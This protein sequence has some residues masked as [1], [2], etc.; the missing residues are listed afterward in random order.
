[1]TNDKK[2]EDIEFRI[3]TMDDLE[4]AV[5]FSIDV[6]RLQEPL[7]NTMG[8]TP[9]E[10]EPLFRWVVKRG[11]SHNHTGLAFHKPSGRLI[12]FLTTTLWYREKEA[13]QY[14]PFPELSLRCKQ[15]GDILQELKGPFWELC[16]K[17]VN[18][19]LRRDYSCVHKD[20]QR[21]GIGTQ[22]DKLFADP[23]K[24]KA[25]NIDGVISETSS[26]ANQAVLSKRG[27]VV[28]K[29]LIYEE[30]KDEHG[31]KILPDKLCDGSTK[32]VLN[33]KK[34]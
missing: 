2:F 24:L 33:F 1:M 7:A 27:Y 26:V 4:V 9:S 22:L 19:V 10:A 16:P 17:D 32:M 25:E 6:F 21:R 34:C 14:E 28:L 15:L 29:E 18:T 3:A 20:F 30:Y 31:Q 12:G 5:D 13:N 11:I 23:E 8:F